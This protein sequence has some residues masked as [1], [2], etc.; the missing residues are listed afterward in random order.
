MQYL[1]SPLFVIGVGLTG[2]AIAGM[3]PSVQADLGGPSWDVS[4]PMVVSLPR[5][6]VL[7]AGGVLMVAAHVR[8]RST[9]K[10]N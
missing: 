9:M 3:L 1:K 7:L 6:G 10:S 5:V 8:L 4:A 2:W